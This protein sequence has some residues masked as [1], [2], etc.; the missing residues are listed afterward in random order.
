LAYFSNSR[1]YSACLEAGLVPT[2]I[3]TKI[4]AFQTRILGGY[5]LIPS[6]QQ[7]NGIH[8][9]FINFSDMLHISYTTSKV[10]TIG[11]NPTSVKF[12]SGEID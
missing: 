8:L 6:E 3:N 11:E 1:S 7:M 9:L 12:T 4:V 5:S 2:K 10:D